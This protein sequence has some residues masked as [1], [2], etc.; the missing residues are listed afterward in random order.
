MAGLKR[1]P[2]R[3]R[4][5]PVRVQFRRGAVVKEGTLVD[6]SRRSAL[7]KGFSRPA[8][9]RRAPVLTFFPGESEP[10]TRAC[11]VVRSDKTPVPWCAFEFPVPLTLEE[12]GALVLKSD[13]YP[14]ISTDQELAEEIA[15]LFRGDLASF[16]EV[17][18]AAGFP[19]ESL[20]N[21]SD[22]RAIISSF[23]H[24]IPS[25]RPSLQGDVARALLYAHPKSDLLRLWCHVLFEITNA[26]A[27]TKSTPLSLYFDMSEFSAAGI[28]DVLHHLSELYRSIGGDGLIINEMTL[29]EPSLVP[30]G[31]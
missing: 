8:P 28:A 4:T 2:G 10:I 12:L 14:S 20:S 6:V 16:R 26:E 5:K 13:L 3:F 15:H 30:E 31:V 22:P 23:V 17:V 27:S 11:R 24:T 18:E 29:L 7:V 25:L 19:V 21:V 9:G 1:R